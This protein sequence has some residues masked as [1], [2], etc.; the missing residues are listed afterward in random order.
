[1]D[2]KKNR[3]KWIVLYSIGSIYL[4][5]LIL[6]TLS[7]DL[8]SILFDRY[9]SGS[10]IYFTNPTEDFFSKLKLSSV[11]THRF[12]SGITDLTNS[13]TKDESMLIKLK[14]Y[15]YD[16][17]ASEKSALAVSS[18]SNGFVDMEQYSAQN[19][20][21]NAN[22]SSDESLLTLNMTNKIKLK[23]FLSGAKNEPAENSSNDV[24]ATVT[25]LSNDNASLFSVNNQDNTPF[26]GIGINPGGDPTG[27]P[28]PVGDSVPFLILLAGIYAGWKWISLKLR[29]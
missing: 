18:Y 13:P 26:Q 11:Y 21:S 15:S 10:V 20:K 29:G 27:D 24:V 6:N 19:S 25:D 4:F 1:M 28:I 23:S 22:G 14:D 12:K 16:Y 5:V 2:K 7:I 17:S 9:K 8:L 3:N